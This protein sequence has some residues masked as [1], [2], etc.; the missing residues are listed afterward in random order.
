MQGIKL[1]VDNIA[2]ATPSNPCGTVSCGMVLD[3]GEIE[4]L[5]HI[6]VSRKWAQDLKKK[7]PQAPPS[8][9]RPLRVHTQ[10]HLIFQGLRGS[11][12][13]QLHLD[14]LITDLHWVNSDCQAQF[15][16]S[17]HLPTFPS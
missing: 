14:R 3:A 17:P 4:P 5:K 2:R 7:I 10:G 16:A 15:V 13:D 11:I 8:R 12:A 1:N 9:V 6:E